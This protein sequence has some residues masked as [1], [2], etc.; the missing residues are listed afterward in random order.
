MKRAAAVGIDL[1]TSGIRA[2]AIDD[3]GHSLG[4]GAYKSTV[5][6]AA[7]DPSQWITGVE[8]C[9][10]QLRAE[11]D[12]SGV[13]AVSVD[14]TS[15][16]VLAL[17]QSG[18]P[19]EPAALYNAPVPSP[20]IL[21]SIDEHAPHS[22]PARGASSPL[23]KAID[24]H[25]RL[26]PA[27]IVHQADWLAMQLGDGTALSDEN[28]ALKTGYD[29]DSNSWPEWIA[30]AGLPLDLLPAVRPA[31]SPVCTTGSWARALGLPAACQVHVGTTDGCAS[32]LATGASEI[33][34]GVTALGS[35]LV[36]KLLS[37]KRI[38]AP[39]FGIYSHRVNG[40][41]LAGGASNT[42]GAVIKALLPDADLDALS[43]RINPETPTGL[44][45]Y[46]LARPGERFPVS[47][48][49]LQ[50]R[51]LPRP[52]DD[53]VYFQGLLEGISDIEARGYGILEQLG[54]PPLASVRTVGGGAANH[55]WARLRM[56]RLGVPF[57]PAQSVEAA[58]GV[59]RLALGRAHHGHA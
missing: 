37:A 38:E 27:R 53:A 16:T 33:G 29:L 12:L 55:A 15:G 41:W 43:A 24:L 47:A 25:R 13:M 35:S 21:A 11:V 18:A 58:V 48:P 46:P 52:D 45:Y 7:R 2:A 30:R 42:G 26:S 22:S 31:G 49:D 1:G 32:F 17:D 9:F 39:Q 57:L 50:P 19:I 5:A 44:S 28:N 36:L 20:E 34:D 54:G 3:D 14:G 23:G 10:A 8:S 59:A 4:L 40:M 56:R 6:E 51:V